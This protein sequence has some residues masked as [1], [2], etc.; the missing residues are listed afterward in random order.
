MLSKWTWKCPKVGCDSKSKISAS[1]Y[2]VGRRGRRHLRIFHNDSVSE[3]I[4][5]KAEMEAD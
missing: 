1:K 4:F 5:K 2:V 3:P